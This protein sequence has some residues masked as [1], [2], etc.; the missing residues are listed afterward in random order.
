MFLRNIPQN[1]K[2]SLYTFRI[3]CEFCVLLLLQKNKPQNPLT[4]RANADPGTKCCEMRKVKKGGAK[5]EEGDAKYLAIQFSFLAF[6]DHFHIFYDKCIAGF[7]VTEFN[8]HA[9]IA[10]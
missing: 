6:C 7:R 10:E 1:T 3:S 9:R 8:E 2:H 4:F 5:C